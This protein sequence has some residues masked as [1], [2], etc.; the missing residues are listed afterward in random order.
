MDPISLI[1][2]ALVA[3]AAASSKEVAGSAIKD[4]YNG[5]KELIIRKFGGNAK[6]EQ[7]LA[8][9]EQDAETYE[10][11]L[12]KMLKQAGADQDQSILEAAQQLMAQVDSRGAAAGDYNIQF[13]GP[14]NR[15]AIGRD[16]MQ[17]HMG[18]EYSGERTSD[19]EK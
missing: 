9:H 5:F 2:A 18:D 14:V 8:D 12:G 4:A 13:Y 1:V 6:A 11:P 15:A 10:K 16:N 17:V 3:G 19:K 7:T